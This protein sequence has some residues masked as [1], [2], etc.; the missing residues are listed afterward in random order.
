MSGFANFALNFIGLVISASSYNTGAYYNFGSMG[1]AG[2]IFNSCGCDGVGMS[3][4]A[5]KSMRNANLKTGFAV[6]AMG[7]AALALGQILSGDTKAGLKKELAEINKNI[8]DTLADL[9]N[10]ATIENYQEKITANRKVIADVDTTTTQFEA[11]NLE[12]SNTTTALDAA[13]NAS[14][15]QEGII[16]QAEITLSNP[17]ASEADRAAAEK[18]KAE[19]EFWNNVKQIIAPNSV[20]N[21]FIFFLR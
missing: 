21:F 14:G 17:N 20:N 12:L 15:V 13:I 11:K 10:G 16:S 19:A 2:S 8:N 9:G 3:E 1:C 18:Q 7:I 5:Q 6:G 4:A